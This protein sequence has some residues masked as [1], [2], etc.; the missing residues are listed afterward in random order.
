MTGIAHR[1]VGGPIHD[2]AGLKANYNNL[3]DS[4]SYRAAVETGTSQEA[5]VTTRLQEAQTAFVFLAL[6]ANAKSIAKREGLMPCSTVF[7]KL[8]RNPSSCQI[9][10]DIYAC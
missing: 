2:L 3:M 1:L 9:W 5:N 8:E 4:G 7:Q 10:R 6:Q